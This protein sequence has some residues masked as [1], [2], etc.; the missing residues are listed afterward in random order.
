MFRIYSKWGMRM[1]NFNL[2]LFVGNWEWDYLNTCFGL[3]CICIFY[4]RI[5]LL[6]R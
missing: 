1:K 3:F 4:N 5:V 2:E 6:F